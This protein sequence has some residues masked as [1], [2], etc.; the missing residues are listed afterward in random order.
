MKVLGQ[1]FRDLR[2][3]MI[4]GKACHRRDRLLVLGDFNAPTGTDSDGYDKGVRPHWSGT[5]NRIARSSLALLEVMQFG[6][7]VHGFSDHSLIDGLRSPTL[8]V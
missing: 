2:S 4:G 8:V 3:L 7:L 6:W 5:V 1:S